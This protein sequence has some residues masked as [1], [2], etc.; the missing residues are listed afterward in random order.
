MKKVLLDTN[1]L[2]DYPETLTEYSNIIMPNCI[3]EE[4]DGLKKSPEEVGYKARQAIKY[5]EKYIDNIFFII[6][7]ND[8]DM[9]DG[10]DSNLRDNKIIM[11]AKSLDAI[12]FSNDINV[13]I[14]AKS[15]DVESL[16]YGRKIDN[17]YTGFH[18]IEM[19]KEECIDWYS[20]NRENKWDLHINQ[21]LIIEHEDDT[22]ESW[23][24]GKNGFR[25]INFSKKIESATLGKFTSKDIYQNC[26]LDSLFNNDMTMIKGKAGSG[27]SLIALSYAMNQI[28]KGKYD[29]LIVFANPV[30]SK[31]AAKLGFLPGSQFEKLADSSLGH[32]LSSKFGDKMGLEKLIKEEKV[33]LLPFSDIRG[34]DTSG[35]KAI[36]WIVEAQNLDIELM[37]LAIQRI[38]AD[39]KLIID[40]DYNAQ[41][42]VSAYEGS[43]NGMRRVSEV[44]RG[45][46]FY[47]EV[48]L[49]NIYRSR[50]AEVADRL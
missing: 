42:D 36:C 43:Q 18:L 10:W 31:N 9:P 11:N 12:L 44:F 28:E 34:F 40:G 7:D 6:N 32:M 22:Y 48:E 46:D 33:L 3:L 26:A 37:R 50:F 15:I 1:V 20:S 30:A 41:V 21:Y 24:Y 23:V 4:L 19:T 49:Q 8:Y 2:I 14:K 29:K 17:S 25:L 5:I 16:P 13:R 45:Q 39:C 27:K 38:G 35:M 47:G